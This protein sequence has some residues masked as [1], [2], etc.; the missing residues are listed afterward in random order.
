[1]KINHSIFKSYDI[2]GI[3]PEE[4]NKETAYKIG[5]TFVKYTGAKRVL[6]GRDGR[7]SSSGL[8]KALNQG[9]RSQGSDVGD[10]GQVPTE[11]LYFSVGHYNY[12][13]G[14]MITASHNPKEYNGFK[15]IQKQGA[16]LVRV[17]PGKEIGKV[18]EELP[19]K[20]K[21]K[22]KRIDIWQDYINHIFSFINPKKIK[23]FKV[24][25]D[26]GNGMAGRVIPR[27]SSKLPIK[28][29]SL[30]FKLDGS[31]PNH[32][33][34]P[35]EEGSADQIIKA[36]KKEKADFGF[37]FDGDADRI[38]LIDEKGNFIK[39]DI[40]GLLLAKYLLEKHPGRG[41]A[42]NVVCSK[43][44]PEFIKKWGGKAIRTA[45]GFINVQQGIRENDGLMGIEL[46]G[47]YC[48]KDNY[49][50]DSGFIAFLILLQI[51]S[52]S[53]EKASSIIKELSVYTKGSEMNFE[54]QNKEEMLKKFRKKF[55]EGKQ[56]FLDGL[57]V[58]YQD[59]WFNI[60]PS[61]TEPL[62]RLTIEANNLELLEQKK[63]E[64]TTFIKKIEH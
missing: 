4:L 52:A 63:K 55:S 20:E 5:Q 37:I 28:I 36:V 40:T 60:R 35:L 34:N 58:E 31:F 17:I 25:I 18:I 59:W 61:N 15:L 2:R 6:V 26:A 30:N 44:V 14:I 50:L 27:I 1:M 9:L 24:V 7:L 10:I 56:D 54:V 57:T 32:S 41:I 49:Y 19:A 29:I 33:P 39:A 38:F 22:I 8:F 64:L 47:H 45:V 46:S 21:G 48:F 13:A 53:N 23:P 43:A 3:F 11:G 42:H 62:V 12:G 51:I 16:N